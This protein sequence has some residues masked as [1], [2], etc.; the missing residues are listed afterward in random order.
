M[1]LAS[2]I[3]LIAVLQLSQWSNAKR[4]R[5]IRDTRTSCPGR[6]L[7]EAPQRYHR[8]RYFV[9]M[10]LFDLQEF[11]RYF[12]HETKG[13]GLL[14]DV[15]HV[16]VEEACDRARTMKNCLANCTSPGD[17]RSRIKYTRVVN[18]TSA[19]FCD[20]AV[21]R[22]YDCL[23]NVSKH[24]SHQCKIRCDEFRQAVVHGQNENSTSSGGFGLPETIRGLCKLVNCRL[25]CSNNNIINSCDQTAFEAAKNFV[26]GLG[27][28][29]KEYFSF[30]DI[31][32]LFPRDACAVDALLREPSTQDV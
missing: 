26:R 27:R 11:V 17:R 21:Q 24:A 22:Q 15:S 1:K 18:I 14:P 6:C 25:H 32:Y 23:K 12:S 16:V 13:A 9:R 7:Y 5:R 29:T 2:L 8:H 28:L 4:H 20:P 3:L 19:I 10:H 31:G 30:Y